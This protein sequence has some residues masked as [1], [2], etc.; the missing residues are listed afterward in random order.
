MPLLRQALSP[1][2]LVA[3]PRGRYFA[4]RGFLLWVSRGALTGTATWDG[5]DEASAAQLLALWD[6]LRTA[7]K[8]PLD[9][10]FDG[11]RM[12]AVAPRVFELFY[13]Y[14]RDRVVELGETFQRQAMILPES[15]AGAAMGGVYPLSGAAHA[16]RLFQDAPLAF[17]WLD[18]EHGGALHDEVEALLVPLVAQP[19]LLANVRA[20]LATHL[21]GITL[22][23]VA[24]GLGIS[25]RSLQRSLSELGTSLRYELECARVQ[26]AQRLLLAGDEKLDEIAHKA[27]CAN[28]ASL[29]RLFR[30]HTGETPG[31]FRQKGRPT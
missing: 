6:E 2:D 18:P 14:V 21:S 22:A 17:D 24:R 5:F 9:V 30:R 20:R 15:F 29:S 31:R 23:V 19:A 10:V 13:E 4:G 26:A 7:H 3:R 11:R 12:S 8:Q 28:G 16:W 25:A 27:G 1:G